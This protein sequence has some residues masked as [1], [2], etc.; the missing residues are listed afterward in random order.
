MK[1]TLAMI[2]AALMLSTTLIACSNEAGTTTDTTAAPNIADT[3]VPVETADPTK[4]ANGYL[5]DSLPADLNFGGA[6]IGILHWNS[7]EKEFEIEEITGD[8]LNDAIFTR[9]ETVQNRLNVK[10]DFVGTKANADN[11]AN[12]FFL[13]YGTINNVIQNIEDM[14]V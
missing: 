10:L 3:T 12:Y 6:E 7:E 11:V 9:N 14:Y 1:R 4:D 13:F 5:L 2:L 8:I